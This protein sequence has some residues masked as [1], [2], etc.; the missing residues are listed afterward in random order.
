MGVN[1]ASVKRPI[2][3][4]GP[5]RP[6]RQGPRDKPNRTPEPEASKRPR[7]LIDLKNPACSSADRRPAANAGGT[8]RRR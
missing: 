5:V 7:T 6:S 4:H 8:R 3:S 1:A 2:V